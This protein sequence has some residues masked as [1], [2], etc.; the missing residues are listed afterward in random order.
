MGEDHVHV[1]DV[2]QLPSPAF[3]H[4]DDGQ[5]HLQ[6]I[7]TVLLHRLGPGHGQARLDR[8]PGQVRQPERDPRLGVRRLLGLQVLQGDGGQLPPVGHPQCGGRVLAPQRG[9]RRCLI[10]VGSHGFEQQPTQ[11]VGVR[12]PALRAQHRCGG[13]RPGRV[14]HQVDVLGPA[15]QELAQGFGGSQQ[16]HQTP[17]GVRLLQRRGRRRCPLDQPDQ[18]EQGLV[19][20]RRVGEDAHHLLGRDR[21]QLRGLQQS[22][23]PFDLTESGRHQSAAARCGLS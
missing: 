4:P 2:V 17:G 10:R 12:L 18:Q 21:G 23:G 1:G 20:V 11:P 14:Q 22:A 3:A 19:R 16:S 15:D 13:G 5:L 7:L 6:R 9:D 8:R